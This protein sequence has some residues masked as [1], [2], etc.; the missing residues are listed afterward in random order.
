MCYN[1]CSFKVFVDTVCT[2]RE[3]FRSVIYPTSS[4]YSTLD[5]VVFRLIRSKHT[6]RQESY[7]TD[8]VLTKNYCKVSQVC[9]PESD[10]RP[11]FE[12]G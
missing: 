8:L 12:D 1:F 9:R 10:Y 7:Y 6:T 2:D 5:R 3:N 11:S 4:A